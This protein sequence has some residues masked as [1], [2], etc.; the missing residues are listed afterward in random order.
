[1]GASACSA[2]FRTTPRHLAMLLGALA[3]LG[4]C[5]AAGADGYGDGDGEGEIVDVAWSLQPRRRL[6]LHDDPSTLPAGEEDLAVS[7][8]S[9]GT[10]VSLRLRRN[11]AL[12]PAGARH[13]LRYKSGRMEEGPMPKACFFVG[14]VAGDKSSSAS[15]S[16]CSGGLSGFIV[17][18]GRAIAID[19]LPGS[20]F[21]F[22][23][24]GAARYNT[25]GVRTGRGGRLVV[26][27]LSDANFLEMQTDIAS[28]VRG[29]AKNSSLSSA[30]R[31]TGS[32]TKYVETFVVNDYRRYEAFG[33]QSGLA[34][35]AEHSVSVL[36]AVTAIYRNP[37]TDGSSFPYTVQIV[38]VGQ[39]TFLEEDPWE[40]TVTLVGSETD[41][42]SL[43]D[44][45][46][47][48]GQNQ[49]LAG[50]ASVKEYD[51][52]VLLSGRD[53][54]GSTIGLAGMSTMCMMSRSG[55]VNMCGPASSDVA[56]CAAVV[57]H[58]MGHNFGMSHDSTG[59]DCSQ[60]GFIMESVSSGDASDQ[61]SSCSATYISSF[62][63][64]TYAENG[65]CLENMPSR[66]EG[67]PI[68]GNG[69]VEDGEDCDC[70]SSDCSSLDSCCNGETCKF[71]DPS[72][73]CS[74][75]AGP[76]CESCMFVSAGANKICRAQKNECDLPEYCPGGTADCSF[77]DY[78]YPG[79]ACTVNGF[80]GLCSTGRCE[81]LGATC[82]VDINRDFPGSWD[83]TEDCAV[84]NDQCGFLVCH[85]ASS[86]EDY[87]CGQSFTT[88][89]K[90]MTVPEGTPCWFPGSA[91]GERLGMCSAGECKLPHALAAVP[92]CGNGGIDYGEECD[93]GDAETDPCC[94]CTTCKLKA[95][96][97]CSASEPCCDSTCMFK[98][99]GT[100][101]RAAVG[102][103]DVQESCSGSSGVCPSDVGK[104]WGTA[105]TTDAGQAST[106]YAKVCIDSLNKQCSDKTNGAK[107]YIK[108]DW[109]GT[110]I[111]DSSDCTALMCCT[112]CKVL[113][114]SYDIN[115]ATYENPTS[116]T[117]C[118]SES[119]WV[120]FTA[121]DGVKNTIYLG[122]ADDGSVLSDTSKI[123][124]GS[125]LVT[126]ASSCGAGE[127]LEVAVGRCLAC[128]SSCTE[129]T[130]PTN[131]DCTGAC[132]YGQDSRGACAI[133]SEQVT[134]S[135]TSSPT[136]ASTLAPTPGGSP[137]PTL[138]PTPEPSRGNV[139]TPA[140]TPAPTPAPAQ[141]QTPTPSPAE[142]GQVSFEMTVQNVDYTG[143]NSR[144]TLLEAFIAELKRVIAALVN[145]TSHH[146]QVA[147]SEGSVKV[148]SRI[149]PPPSSGVTAANIE[150]ALNT[151]RESGSLNGD[152][153]EGIS[154]L[155]GIG[156]V[157]TGTISVSVT[158]PVVVTPESGVASRASANHA[159]AGAEIAA[160][161][162]AA[163]VAA[164]A[165]AWLAAEVGPLG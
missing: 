130:G 30:R 72:Y 24:P 107:P 9:N 62:F 74:G 139:P 76:C 155:A 117:P 69:F 7:F 128:D 134:M 105:C 102:E 148:S 14:E 142:A 12:M 97:E 122:A 126:P 73:E 120:S 11:S 162:A 109:D 57:A 48:W 65:E 50:L 83:L 2:P 51:N 39:Q 47:T 61:F 52:R 70:G 156:E 3:G 113:S 129:C 101:C 89:G 95:G 45:F 92:V 21:D 146:V 71:A 137:T 64:S 79:K 41:C 118:A 98:T 22:A 160:A 157:K 103:C 40:Q 23:P 161:T 55:N 96:K 152:V 4:L 163:A 132:K 38:M 85:D 149:T 131:F 124:L 35:L 15:V 136:P 26:R 6:S 36:N 135:R 20:S 116:C 100:V 127:F 82:S 56:G 94:E 37:P 33:G 46:N 31:L 125:T 114:G 5:A 119:S 106:C 91:L 147:L 164:V 123:C 53:F 158:A 138:A 81:S 8:T 111:T 28:F 112:D 108:F 16:T 99:Q 34:D 84:Y 49:L 60:S 115:G 88:H 78:A 43:L 104:Q 66:V 18:W 140:A 44:H 87:N 153:A 133:D 54:D 63:S 93:C 67:D 58:E 59:N 141:E 151:G 110:S 19:P 77:D 68:C 32:A 27:R 154:G 25:S 80:S 29:R 159:G 165:A 143:L 121:A 75:G 10:A 150:A 90:Q 145:L 86:S 13:L 42:S 1:M 17:T 144:T